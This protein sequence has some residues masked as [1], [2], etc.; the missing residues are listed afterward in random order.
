MFSQRVFAER[1]VESYCTP[2]T[3]IIIVLANQRCKDAGKVA[4]DSEHEELK[5]D[6]TRRLN[7]RFPIL[8]Q[9]S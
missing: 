2:H 5:Q 3:L 6:E 7:H 8:G 9:V 4:T 1:G